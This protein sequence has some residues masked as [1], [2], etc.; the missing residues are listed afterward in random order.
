MP[1]QRDVFATQAD[2]ARLGMQHDYGREMQAAEQAG[3][4]DLQERQFTYRDKLRMDAITN[5]LA[6]VDEMVA[7]RA[8]APEDRDMYRRAAEAELGPLQ[9]QEARAR[10]QHIAEQ[11]RLIDA[12]T[13]ATTAR[14]A[15]SERFTNAQ[16]SNDPPRVHVDP[17]TGMRFLFTPRQGWQHIQERQQPEQAVDAYG[18]PIGGT[19]S[20]RSSGGSSAGS[21]GGGAVS[22]NTPRTIHE[23][24]DAMRNEIRNFERD[25]PTQAQR[26]AAA[27]WMRGNEQ[28]FLLEMDRRHGLE[29]RAASQAQRAM[30]LR[31]NGPLPFD[32]SPIQ[33]GERPTAE[34]LGTFINFAI[35]NAEFS[36]RPQESERWRAIG[37][38]LRDGAN[39][40]SLKP[41]QQEM[42]ARLGYY[43]GAFTPEMDR[44]INQASFRGP[45]QQGGNQPNAAVSPEERDNP[46]SPGNV[47][48]ARLSQYGG[49]SQMPPHTRERVERSLRAIGLDP[50]TH[51]AFRMGPQPQQAPNANNNAA[52]IAPPP[53]MD[54]QQNWMPAPMM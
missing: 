29:Q 4:V 52:P 39:T 31:V 8:I 10:Q 12:Q 27:P 34:R 19:A 32:E 53:P 43:H 37:V 14:A 2:F 13:A 51:P 45:V 48:R 24:G 49:L 18:F 6:L 1:S 30:A 17:N 40:G 28:A 26:D 3:R 33:P 7:R 23:I 41:Q 22:V 9:L 35:R 36:R 20:G 15:E 46:L 38:A 21:S 42:L 50:A 54:R 16:L 5:N 25:N 44:L 47:A 11:N